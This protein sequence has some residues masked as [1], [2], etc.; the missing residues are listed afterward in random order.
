VRRRPGCRPRRGLY[1]AAGQDTGENATAESPNR[2]HIDCRIPESPLPSL[3]D[4][5]DN[6]T[7]VAAA[8]RQRGIDVLLNAES[9]RESPAAAFSHKVCLLGVHASGA[10]SSSSPP[11]RVT[12]GTSRASLSPST[13]SQAHILA[14]LLAY[15]TQLAEADL[16]LLV[17]DC[18]ISVPCY[19]TQAQR[20]AYVECRVRGGRR[21]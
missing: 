16:E 21:G 18:V 15:L 19:F 13:P 10:A 5:R 3:A 12:P 14:I 11:A 20:G 8:A 7:L 6:N 17:A 1:G 4:R 2:H 9:K